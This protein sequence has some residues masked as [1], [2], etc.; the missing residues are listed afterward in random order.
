MRYR[1]QASQKF[2]SGLTALLIVSGCSVLRPDRAPQPPKA[3]AAMTSWRALGA[4]VEESAART[5]RNQVQHGEFSISHPRVAE[6][7]DEFQ[8]ERRTFF[9]RALERSGKYVPSMRAILTS[10]GLPPEL[11]YLPIIESGFRPEAVSPAGAVGPWQ[12]IRGTGK[13]YGLRIDRYVDE[14]RDPIESTRAAARYLRDL[15]GMFGSWQLSLAA[16]NTGEMRIVRILDRDSSLDFWDMRERGYLHPETRDY[17]PQFL[18]AVAIAREPQRHGFESPD[19]TLPRYDTVHVDRSLSFDTVAEL[20]NVSVREIAE[21]NPALVRRVTPPDSDG[22]EI[23][24]PE[25]TRERFETAYAAYVRNGGVSR[26][27]GTSVTR[28]AAY[29]RKSV[30]S[31]ASRKAVKSLH[32]AK[33]GAREKTRVTS[34]GKSK[35]KSKVARASKRSVKAARTNG[36]RPGA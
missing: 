31:V 2:L 6:W 9:Q 19:L 30:R 8:N 36:L 24:I 26:Q 14:R 17:V 11:V 18:A 5:A 27:A 28:K 4:E 32:Q 29:A 35:S 13:R 3:A 15:Y 33:G 12:F 10:E 16:Y 1:P 20:A 7:V 34:A 25:G 21:L 23:R 22:Y